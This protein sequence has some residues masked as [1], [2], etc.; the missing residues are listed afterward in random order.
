MLRQSHQHERYLITRQSELK[1][2]SGLGLPLCNDSS[3]DN[4][5]VCAVILIGQD[6][7]NLQRMSE[8]LPQQKPMKILRIVISVRQ[9]LE[10]ASRRDCIRRT[11]HEKT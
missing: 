3:P 4:I 10:N 2:L 1:L 11:N 8:T 7:R 9:L 5:I 6:L